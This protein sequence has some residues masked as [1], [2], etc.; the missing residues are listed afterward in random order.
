LFITIIE[1]NG[2]TCQTIQNKDKF[3][4]REYLCR[5][6]KF[7]DVRLIIFNELNCYFFLIGFRQKKLSPNCSRHCVH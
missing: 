2:R 5:N 6:P 3:I 7:I 4:P 1:D